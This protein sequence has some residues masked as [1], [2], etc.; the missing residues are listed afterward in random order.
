MLNSRCFLVL[1]CLNIRKFSM[2]CWFFWFEQL[3]WIGKGSCLQTQY[4]S[5]SSI[6]ESVIAPNNYKYGQTVPWPWLFWFEH[7][8]MQSFLCRWWTVESIRLNTSFCLNVSPLISFCPSFRW[9]QIH[10]TISSKYAHDRKKNYRMQWNFRYPFPRFQAPP[11]RFYMPNNSAYL[12]LRW[13][14]I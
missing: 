2:N 1:V 4:E 12:D 10:T 6:S 3:T 9:E 11:K 13:S 8:I 14:S 5:V 7:E